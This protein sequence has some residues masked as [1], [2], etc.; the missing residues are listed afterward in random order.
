ML[1]VFLLLAACANQEAESQKNEVDNATPSSTPKPVASSTVTI[2]PSTATITPSPAIAPS[3]TNPETPTPT[4]SDIPWSPPSFLPT[5]MVG[6]DLSE[7]IDAWKVY[8][9]TQ[10]GFSFEYP[11]IYDEIG[12]CA[13]WENEKTTGGISIGIGSRISV[14]VEPVNPEYT[15][16]SFVEEFTKNL[17]H[18]EI[19]PTPLAGQDGY[20]I[21]YR[22]G[23]LGRLD[24][25][26]VVV[27][28]SL[29]VIFE[30][31][32]P[33]GCDI[34]EVGMKERDVFDHV[35]ESFTFIDE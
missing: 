16:D 4:S 19:V 22:Y 23:G 27:N 2:I 11:V 8:S 32:Y 29:R 10:Y 14:D 5:E 1:F 31:T 35:M 24:E 18:L 34:W 21:S 6:L 13:I 3:A 30:M 17:E 7:F 25:V 33:V 28:D 15:I 26:F 20:Y 12:Y 9:N